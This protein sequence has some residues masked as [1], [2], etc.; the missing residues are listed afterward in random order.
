M[1]PG[2]SIAVLLLLAACRSGPEYMREVNPVRVLKAP[3]DRALVVFVRPQTVASKSLAHVMD[4]QG[5]FLGSAPAGGHFSVVRNPGP[6]KFIV[7]SEAE[8]VLV[9]TLAPGLVYFVEINVETG[10]TRERF[11]MRAS[12]RGSQIFPYREQW[13]EETTQYRVDL[14]SAKDAMA[15]EAPMFKQVLKDAAERLGTYS[16]AEL[17]AHTL[18]VTDGHSAVGIPAQARQLTAAV[19]PVAQQPAVRPVSRPPPRP[20][21][22]P[23][24]YGYQT[25]PTPQPN[26]QQ[27]QA[28]PAQP[29]PGFMP[30]EFPTPPPPGAPPEVAHDPNASSAPIEIPRGYPRGSMVR[31]TLKDGKV[32]T[33]E[34]KNETKVDLKIVNPQ[35]THLFDFDEM[36]SVERIVQ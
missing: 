29:A 4:E 33:G 21:A 2:P 35:G 22:N 30:E 12:R 23:Q 24:P 16:G 14:K 36:A 17:A 11:T 25:Q 7:W 18:V 5:T 8:D 31:I 32:F 19:A 9:A 13:L 28:Q 27:P 6:Q 3:V 10:G 20:A 1:R 15:E 34:V 26:Y